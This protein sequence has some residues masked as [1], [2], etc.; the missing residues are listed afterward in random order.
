MLDII[1]A[2]AD[3]AKA[4]P[5]QTADNLSKIFSGGREVSQQRTPQERLFHKLQ[6]F[7]NFLEVIRDTI[8][9]HHRMTIARNIEPWNGPRG[10]V[11]S[12][13]IERAYQKP[14]QIYN[15]TGKELVGLQTT[16]PQEVQDGYSSRNQ[17][18]ADTV[19]TM[20]QAVQAD[21]DRLLQVAGMLGFFFPGS[22]MWETRRKLR[23]HGKYHHSDGFWTSFQN[24]EWGVVSATSMGMYMG[25]VEVADRKGNTKL[26]TMELGSVTSNPTFESERSP[27]GS[28]SARTELQWQA[29]QKL[30]DERTRALVGNVSPGTPGWRELVTKPMAPR[31]NYEGQF[32]VQSHRNSKL[33][34]YS[35]LYP[36][37]LWLRAGFHTYM[38]DL[39]NV[40]EM[41]SY[42]CFITA[43]VFKIKMNLEEAPTI[44]RVYDTLLSMKAETTSEVA[45]QDIVQVEDVLAVHIETFKQY[46]YYYMITLV[47]NSMLM[48]FKL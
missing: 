28:T 34:K 12:N 3:A 21:L 8:K 4:L 26:K 14:V 2:V 23:E 33:L 15:K 44:Q 10:V 25:K 13:T 29:H 43:F 36:L 11:L 31:V 17:I 47:P 45:E 46:T 39:W 30:D 27:D 7:V 5:K 24:A 9:L 19:K 22:P 37:Y 1:S 16:F 32:I 20:A 35:K 48:W 42:L 18:K 41:V 6:P 38:S 40:A